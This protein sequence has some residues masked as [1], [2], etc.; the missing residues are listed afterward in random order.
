MSASAMSITF[1]VVKTVYRGLNVL[2]YYLYLD[3]EVVI[4]S[5]GVFSIQCALIVATIIMKHVRCTVASTLDEYS[6]F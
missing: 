5:A 2:Q 1:L 3:L 4:K 6:V